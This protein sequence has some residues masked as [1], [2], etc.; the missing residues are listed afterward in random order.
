MPTYYGE[1]FLRISHDELFTVGWL[2]RI[3][4]SR[5]NATELLL[6]LLL[7]LLLYLRFAVSVIG[8][9]AVDSAHK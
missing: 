3:V 7:L 5:T 9:V 6:L 4:R 2:D 1:L 8:L